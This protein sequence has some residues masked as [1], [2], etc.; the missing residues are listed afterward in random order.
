MLLH[1]LHVIPADTLTL[2]RT[3]VNESIT[4]Y[5]SYTDY[6]TSIY[7][8]DTQHFVIPILFSITIELSIVKGLYH[9]RSSM[10]QL[11]ILLR[12]FMMCILW[13]KCFMSLPDNINLKFKGERKFCIQSID[14]LTSCLSVPTS[15]IDLDLN[16]NQ[17]AA[18]W[19]H[20]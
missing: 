17:A 10:R 18:D 4:K 15:N 19:R 11:K 2:N 5:T 12:W 6:W 14:S 13:L 9:A 1:F 16:K 3:E 7:T 8:F 20:Q